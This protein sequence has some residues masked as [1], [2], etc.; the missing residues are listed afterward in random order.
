MADVADVSGA[1]R[2]HL[3]ECFPTEDTGTA[4]LLA[5]PAGW[6]HVTRLMRLGGG[7]GGPVGLAGDGHLNPVLPTRVRATDLNRRRGGGD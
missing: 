6:G 1:V 4:T 2:G 3:L 7:G 5:A